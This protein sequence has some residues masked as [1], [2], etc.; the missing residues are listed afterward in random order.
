MSFYTE[1]SWIALEYELQAI[2]NEIDRSRG[3]TGRNPDW[4]ADL[5][6]VTGLRRK[7][8]DIKQKLAALGN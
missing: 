2:Q 3:K 6:G 1:N 8:S 5:E 7:K 4:A